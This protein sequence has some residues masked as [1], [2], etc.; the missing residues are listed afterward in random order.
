MKKS[1]FAILA[2]FTACAAAAGVSG[3]K[4]CDDDEGPDA[5]GKIQGLLD[6][7]YS[8]IT[9]TVTD[10]F[11]EELSLV[12]A[13]T[14]SYGESDVTVEYSVENFTSLSLDASDPQLK[15][16]KK[17]SV[18]IKDGVVVKQSGDSN[19]F[20]YDLVSAGGLNFKEEY[21]SAVTVNDVTFKADVTNPSGFF[22]VTLACSEM[23][24]NSIYADY[25]AEIVVTYTSSGGH[26]VE[27]EYKFTPAL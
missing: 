27:Y 12:S 10:T 15:T 18:V 14:V 8:Q 7:N 25:L 4:S 9:L 19:V 21:F 26:A 11:S 13:Y 16:V 6:K 22:G 2:V 20:S 17:G 3:C 23:K 24:I 1:I 5:Y